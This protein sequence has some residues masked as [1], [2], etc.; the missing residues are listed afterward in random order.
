[1][2]KELTGRVLKSYNGYYYVKVEGEAED[3]VCKLKGKMKL[4][5][6]SLVTGDFVA[7]E[8]AGGHEGM[9]SRVLPRK[10][11]LPRPAIA[12]LDVFVI[13]FACSRPDFSFLL[14]DKLLLLS[15]LAGIP[16]VLVL[17]KIDTASETLLDGVKS[18]YEKIGCAVYPL[19]A[20]TGEGVGEL[21]QLLKGKVCAFGG[22]SGVGK[23]STINAIDSGAVLRTGSVS[24]KI[25]RGRHTTRYAQLLPFDGGYIADT[26]GFGNIM[27]EGV[28]PLRVAEGFREFAAFGTGC[29]FHPCT[30][31][32]EPVCGIKEAVTE[33][34]ISQSRY[35]SYLAILEELENLRQVQEAREWNLK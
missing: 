33:G 31:T 28:S 12:N 25:G 14:A 30:H 9:L 6:F 4:N 32:H 27:L 1:M 7:L 8:T 5:R 19:S 17:N 35:D 34:F 24:K 26:P 20:K 21:A 10:N 11:F 3:Y 18:V 23:S 16:S 13:T 2:I 29:Y 15:A 22:P